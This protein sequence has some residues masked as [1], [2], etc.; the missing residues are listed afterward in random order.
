MQPSL[1]KGV[2]EA[3]AS[4]ILLFR[5]RR[6]FPFSPGA[7]SR[8]KE[9]QSE[10]SGFASVTCEA[11]LPVTLAL[12]KQKKRDVDYSW[13]V[14]THTSKDVFAIVYRPDIICKYRGILEVAPLYL[15][16]VLGSLE[17]A[18]IMTVQYFVVCCIPGD[19]VA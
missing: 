8:A 2:K 5:T 12:F 1:G 13:S 15:T 19:R 6:I 4:L 17:S 7:C 16:R 14:T 9:N 11:R 3:P 18:L 10:Q